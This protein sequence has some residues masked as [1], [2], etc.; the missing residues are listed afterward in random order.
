MKDLKSALLLVLFLTLLLGGIYPAVVTVAAN[1]LFPHQAEGSLVADGYGRVVGSKLIGQP[2]SEAKYFWPRPSAT[3][4]FA[5]NPLLSAGSN[6]GP[7]HPELIRQ[8]KERI[9]RFRDTGVTG[10]IPADLVFASASG[11]DPH[12]SP[13]AAWLQVPRIAKARGLS[14]EKVHRFVVTTTQGPQAG[15]L[16][17]PRVNVLALNMAL[18]RDTVLP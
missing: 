13:E 16:G 4:A 14:V 10:E 3:A 9:T 12:I 6:L 5:Y 7:T 8:V 1:L 11:L 15:T 2:F 17:A 18:D